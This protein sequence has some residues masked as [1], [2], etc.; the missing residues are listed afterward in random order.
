M[1]YVILGNGVCGTEAALSL[2]KRD[3]GA[4]ITLISHEHDHL[5][6]RPT[7]MYVFCGQVSL[8]GAEPYDRGLYERMRFTRVRERVTALDSDAGRQLISRI[9]SGLDRHGACCLPNFASAAGVERLAEE[10]RTLAPLAYPGPTQASPYFFTG[11]GSLK[12]CRAGLAPI[13]KR[14]LNTA[15]A[16]C[17]HSVG[18]N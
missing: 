7:L 12:S 9:C 3:E 1:H 15:H 5:F 18:L 10:A 2:R 11:P 13:E 14:R 17:R 4:R 6:S 16:L 8:R